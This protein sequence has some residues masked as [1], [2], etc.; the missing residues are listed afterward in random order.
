ME[1]LIEIE[2]F[3]IKHIDEFDGDVLFG[4]IFPVVCNKLNKF[5]DID[6]FFTIFLDWWKNNNNFRLRHDDTEIANE[7]IEY[8]NC[9]LVTKNKIRYRAFL[10]IR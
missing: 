8:Y 2:Y 10:D 9:K 5:D 3:L 7:F 4:I 6:N 1:N